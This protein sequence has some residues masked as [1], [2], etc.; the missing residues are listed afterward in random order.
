MAFSE[1]LVNRVREALIA[2]ENLEEKKMFRGVT[3]MINGKMCVSIGDDELLC[4]IGPDMHETS[5]EKNG[6]RSMIMKGR[7]LK[8][9][10]LV[11]EEGLKTKKDLDHWINLALEFNKK[12]KSTPKRKKNKI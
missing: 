3:F 7:E 5:I 10:V 11:S 1:N 8:G 9:W 12:A 6:C 2:V 4:R